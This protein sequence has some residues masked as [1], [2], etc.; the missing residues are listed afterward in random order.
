M[1]LSIFA[2]TSTLG[3]TSAFVASNTYTQPSALH[4]ADIEATEFSDIVVEE[5]PL[6]PSTPPLP[7]MS[8]SMPF[9]KRP[10]ALT[11]A[12]AGDAG[13]DPL[14]F[15]KTEDDLMN[16][17]EAEIKHARLAMLAAAGWPIS[18]VFDKK[19]AAALNL[20]PLLDA[21]DRVPSILNGGLGKVS[22]LYWV[23]VIGIAAAVDVFGTMK[24]KAGDD[25]YFPGNL[26][27]DPLG[28]Y[29]K[30]EEGQ[31]WMQ[32]AEIKNGRLAMIAVFGFAIQEFVS[33]VGVVDETPFFFYPVMETFK[34]YTNSGYLN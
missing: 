10:A 29:P 30:G 18:E 28:A 7:E 20:S 33:K 12:L 3:S 1:K 26:G 32:T 22:P 14:G 23:A 6:T 24:S 8:M 5:E 34:M 27:F 31:L 4:M 19:I 25:G 13:F 17:R 9:M 21:N 11:G 15:A 16:Y 2:L